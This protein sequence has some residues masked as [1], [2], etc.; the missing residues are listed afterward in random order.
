[1]VNIGSTLMRVTNF[2]M[3]ATYHRVLD[4]GVE[5]FSSPFFLRPRYF[6]K[7]PESIFVSEEEQ[8]ATAVDFGP[9]FVKNLEGSVEWKGFSLPDRLNRRRDENGNIY[10]VSDGESEE[11]GSAG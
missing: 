3:K 7:I 1:M 4:I 8:A 9:Y 10:C 2:T 11:T 6:A 5:R